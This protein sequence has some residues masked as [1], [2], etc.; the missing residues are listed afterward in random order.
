MLCELAMEPAGRKCAQRV[1]L[2]ELGKTSVEFW[3]TGVPAG[4][5]MTLRQRMNRMLRHYLSSGREVD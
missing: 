3:R 4:R 2:Q 5:S 1:A